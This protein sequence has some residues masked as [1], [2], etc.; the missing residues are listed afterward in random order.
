[1]LELFEPDLRDKQG[2]NSFSDST[3]EYTK[4]LGLEW[5]VKL[6]CFQ[7]TIAKS[8]SSNLTKHTLFSNI[9]KVFD[10]LGWFSP[11][12]IKIKIL[13]QRVWEAQVDRDELVPASISEV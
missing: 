1:M 11:A 8:F 2:V 9:A 5:N 13:L 3:S 4:T 6:D 7:L 10:I 12:T